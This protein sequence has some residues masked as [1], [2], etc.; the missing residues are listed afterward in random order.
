[1]WLHNSFII[2]GEVTD[3]S[4]SFNAN[5]FANGFIFSESSPTETPEW[6]SVFGHRISFMNN[7]IIN[8]KKTNGILKYGKKKNFHM[9][10][11]FRFKGNLFLG[12]FEQT[13]VYRDNSNYPV[14]RHVDEDYGTFC[15]ETY[16]FSDFEFFDNNVYTASS[17]AR[18]ANDYVTNPTSNTINGDLDE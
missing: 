12:D 6:H 1:M 11:N 10:L 14:G 3:T 8:A 4:K 2:P 17:C 13:L 5:Y 16:L 7:S 9:G 15:Y 18:H